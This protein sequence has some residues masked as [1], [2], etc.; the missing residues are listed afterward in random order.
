MEIMQ[1]LA[2][3]LVPQDRPLREDV[4]GIGIADI[5]G[6]W[7]GEEFSAGIELDGASGDGR[8]VNGGN[9]WE[10]LRLLR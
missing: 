10:G 4:R 8:L 9:D 2:I 7:P 3:V 5:V 6:H 1:A